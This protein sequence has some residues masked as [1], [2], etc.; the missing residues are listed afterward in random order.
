MLKLMVMNLIKVIGDL[1]TGIID[2]NK[3]IKVLYVKKINSDIN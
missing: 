1:V 2:Q 3:V